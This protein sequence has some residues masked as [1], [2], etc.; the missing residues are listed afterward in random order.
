MCSFCR[1]DHPVET[2]KRQLLGLAPEEEVIDLMKALRANHAAEKWSGRA[3]MESE[4]AKDY[5]V[6]DADTWT[7]VHREPRM[8]QGTPWLWQWG[9]SHGGVHALAPEDDEAVVRG[10]RV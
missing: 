5:W 1:R 9:A 6:K 4:Y 10:L 3:K 2:C 7:R 8:A